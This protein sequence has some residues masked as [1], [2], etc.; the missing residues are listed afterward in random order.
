MCQTHVKTI[1]LA[2][3]RRFMPSVDGKM[4]FFLISELNS[5][6]K[7]SATQNNSVTLS[8]VIIASNVLVKLLVINYKAAKTSRYFANNTTTIFNKKS[9]ISYP[10]LALIV[11]LY[12]KNDYK[13]GTKILSKLRHA[14]Y[15]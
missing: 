13:Y 4:A 7:S 5:L 8:S 10:E 12:H 15:R 9:L 6:Q 11:I 1:L 3:W 14:A 2:R